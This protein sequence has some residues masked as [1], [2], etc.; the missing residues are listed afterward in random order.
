MDFSYLTYLFDARPA[1]GGSYFPDRAGGPFTLRYVAGHDNIETAMRYVDP[2]SLRFTSSFSGR[3]ASRGPRS[4]SGARNRCK[5]RCRGK[6]PW[7]TVRLLITSNL[8]TAE[9]VELADTPS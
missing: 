2:R 6:Y 7:W 9:V 3:P 5:T 4:L 8:Q 1:R